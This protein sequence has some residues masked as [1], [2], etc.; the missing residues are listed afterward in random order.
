MY[1]KNPG[2]PDVRIRK[3]DLPEAEI[4]GILS[5]P[6]RREALRHLD[7]T[8]SAVGV[9]DL[10]A[11][12][13]TAETGQSPPPRAVR[14]S[15]SASLRQTHLPK[16]AELGVLEYDRERREVRLLDAYTDVDPYMDVVTKYGVTWG[17]YYRVLG[18][19]SLSTIVASSIGAPVLSEVDPLLWSS[20]ALAIFALSTAGQLW[21]DRHRLLRSLRGE[22][23]ADERR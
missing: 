9:G 3:F 21:G 10:A 12:I 6:R 19:C 17:E 22:S 20:G 18:V 5:N 8:P 1:F 16:L 23:P 11:A 14:E 2:L 7:R 13:A 4:Y 15:V